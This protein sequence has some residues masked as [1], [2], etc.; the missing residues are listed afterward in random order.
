ME[1]LQLAVADSLHAAGAWRDRPGQLA[2]N[3]AGASPELLIGLLDG[4]DSEEMVDAR[5]L[6]MWSVGCLLLHMLLGHHA[7]TPQQ[8]P[9]SI[10]DAQE[11]L[12]QHDSWVSL[13]LHRLVGCFACLLSCSLATPQVISCLTFRLQRTQLILLVCLDAIHYV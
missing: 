6:D 4:D 10:E 1:D 11:M 12:R 3:V 7:F 5:C 2:F 9:S 8:F 13:H